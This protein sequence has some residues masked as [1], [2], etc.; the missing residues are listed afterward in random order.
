MKIITFS[1]LVLLLVSAACEE[2]TE[3]T[4]FLVTSGTASE[5]AGTQTITINL[6]KTVTSSVTITYIVGG[7]ASVDADYKILSNTN[8]Y[9][10]TNSSF[11]LTVPEGNST[12]TL[13]FELI[14][15]IQ[16]EPVDE[17][18]FFQIT[19]I[20]D[21]DLA[22]AIQN[23][24]YF[25]AVEDNDMPPATGL[26][27]D[28]SWYLEDGISVNNANFDLYLARDVQVNEDG[29]ITAM[30]LLDGVRSANTKGF[31][32][33]V[34]EETLSDDEYY[35]IIRFVKGTMDANVFL[36]MCQGNDY[37]VASGWVT[38][39][40]VGKDIYYGPVTKTGNNFVFR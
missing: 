11:T 28:L 30:E 37:G 39:D 21:T 40:Y 24:Q 29:D 17:S 16:V 8:Y 19:G 5:A 23:T 2:E 31:E 4:G 38:T 32:T 34:M 9:T 1:I 20:S 22:G 36:H 25:F 15:D 7:T 27:V 35:I 14:D 6:G 33:F 26:Q 10:D 13:T 12:A 3:T 18:I